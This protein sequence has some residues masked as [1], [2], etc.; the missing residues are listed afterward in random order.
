[1]SSIRLAETDEPTVELAQRHKLYVDAC[2]RDWT[3]KDFSGN[4]RYLTR[5][6]GITV[7]DSVVFDGG[8]TAPNLGLDNPAPGQVYTIKTNSGSLHPNWGGGIDGISNNDLFYRDVDNT[9]WV[10]A[11]TPYEGYS[12]FDK[13]TGLWNTFKNG[14]WT[15][16]LSLKIVDTLDTQTA[17]YFALN[18]VDPSVGIIN[19]DLPDATLYPG[20]W[21]E[22]KNI[23]NSSNNVVFNATLGQTIDGA[24]NVSDNT[25]YK[26]FRFVS[27]GSNWM[28]TY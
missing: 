28:R 22:A 10:V 16:D 21:I 7:I 11:L 27:D 17:M 1:M 18:R 6:N 23:A 12:V 8:T 14:A 25:A 4:K 9:K 24:A 15:P 19:I 2:S 26:Y 20:G 3:V 5:F 13:S